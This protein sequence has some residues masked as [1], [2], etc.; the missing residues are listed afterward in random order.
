MGRRFGRGCGRALVAGAVAVASACTQNGPVEP[1]RPASMRP[2]EPTIRDH[3]T[4]L[5]GALAANRPAARTTGPVAPPRP[6]NF[7]APFGQTIDRPPRTFAELSA[8][9]RELHYWVVGDGAETV[10]ILGGIHG[11]ERSASRLAYEFLAFVVDHRGALVDRRVVVAPEVNPDGVAAATRRNANDVDLNRNF[12]AQNWEAESAARHWPGNGPA[13][14]PETR[15]VLFLLHEFEPARVVTGHAAAACVNWDGP[16]ETL[17]RLMSRDCGL[18]ARVTIGYAT[19]GSL[20]SY[21]GIERSLPTIT[22]ELSDREQL[23]DER[24]GCLRALMTAVYYPA[25]PPEA[26]LAVGRTPPTD[27]AAAALGHVAK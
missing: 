9:G 14:E 27:A 21:L 1:E 12:P 15:F 25:P 7:V 6:E 4:F 22:L 5:A 24:D 10:L 26:A 23:G 2:D 3:G 16:A 18:P 8:G 19:P 17:A 11:D 13:S 20:G